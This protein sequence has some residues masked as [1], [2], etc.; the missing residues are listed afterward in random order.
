MVKT[1]AHL[2]VEIK[3]GN[4]FSQFFQLDLPLAIHN[5]GTCMNDVAL[6]ITACAKARKQWALNQYENEW[7]YAEKTIPVLFNI[8]QQRVGEL[9][10]CVCMF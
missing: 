9:N 7:L 10:A 6:E 3:R 2:I 4:I 5:C 1:K 8:R